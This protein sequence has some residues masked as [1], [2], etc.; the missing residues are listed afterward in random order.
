MDIL[1]ILMSQLG[2]QEVMET[3]TNQVSGK[4]E[5]VQAATSLAMPTLIKAMTKNAQGSGLE[6]L[7]GALEQHGDDDVEDVSKFL[8]SAD[9][10]D[11]KKILGHLFGG[12]DERKSVEAQVAQKSGLGMDEVGK[13]MAMLAPLVMGYLGNQKK[14]SQMDGG[15]LI[16]LLGSAKGSNLMDAVGDLLGG[17]KE[18]SAGDMLGDVLGGL[19]GKK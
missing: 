6:S 1:E 12:R 14:K 18:S 13:L 7:M 16:D 15:S 4:K 11:G 19:F 8:K 17:S 2:N 5:D 10:A 3:L 9:V